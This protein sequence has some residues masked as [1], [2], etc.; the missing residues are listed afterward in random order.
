MQNCL[1]DLENAVIRFASS[2]KIFLLIFLFGIVF[3]ATL[4]LVEPRYYIIPFALILLFRKF[5][6]YL[7]VE[8]VM[9]V[10]FASIS[11]FLF[12]GEITQLFFL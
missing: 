6:R 7:L 8:K 3:L 9:I 11:F 1:A 4:S 12:W 5:E 2:W 10:L